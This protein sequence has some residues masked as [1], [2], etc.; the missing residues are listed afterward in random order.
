MRAILIALALL[1][2]AA[3]AQPAAHHHPGEDAVDPYIVSDANAGAKPISGARVLAA[4]NGPEGLSRIAAA[5][6]DRSVADPRI[7]DI[8]KQHDLVRI[9][10]TLAEQ[11]CYLAGG[12]CPYTGRDMASS[13][14]DL[15]LQNADFNALV[16]HLQSAMDAEKVPFAAQ[17]RLLAKLAPMQR[18]IVRR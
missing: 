13:H 7:A 11:L 16:E 5:V 15:G 17:N 18:Q 9:K 10:R 4:F 1:P 14:K 2:T 3:L 12:G 8:F 6:I